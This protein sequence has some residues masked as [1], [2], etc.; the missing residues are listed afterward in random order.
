MSDSDSIGNDADQ[1]CSLALAAIL[2][3]FVLHTD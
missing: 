2:Y 3:K 1:T